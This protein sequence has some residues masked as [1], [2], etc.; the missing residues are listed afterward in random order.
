MVTSKN[1]ETQKIWPNNWWTVQFEIHLEEDV[2]ECH[3]QVVNYTNRELDTFTCLPQPIKNNIGKKIGGKV[4]RQE[5]IGFTHA[6]SLSLSLSLICCNLLLV[7]IHQNGSSLAIW[8]EI[9][10]HTTAASIAANLVTTRIFHSFYSTFS[11]SIQS[12]TTH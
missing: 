4:V 10:S 9:V 2:P 3:C 11:F 8:L 7:C 6:S 12:A 5:R 1:D